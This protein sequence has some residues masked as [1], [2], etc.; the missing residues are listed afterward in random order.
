MEN[1]NPKAKG[2]L[3]SRAELALGKLVG[4]EDP[5]Y[6]LTCLRITETRTEVTNGHFAVRVEGVRADT[7][8]FPAP[9]HELTEPKG[10]VLLPRD[11]ALDMAK[12]LPKKQTIRILENALVSEGR[13]DSTDMGGWN[14]KTF[15]KDEATFP[16]MEK[17][18]PL[19]EPKAS[20]CLNAKYLVA[21]VE[22]LMAFK[23]G[24]KAPAIKIEIFSSDTQVRLS[25]VASDLRKVTAIVM[26]M[27]G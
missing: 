6:A 25:L 12:T 26:P 8:N 23:E 13:I 3:V 19:G 21:L 22:S 7:E 18:M 27:R 5:R 9:K 1:E 20:V 11:V 2:W 14:S 16:N 17:V 10:E 4:A 24:A 15:A